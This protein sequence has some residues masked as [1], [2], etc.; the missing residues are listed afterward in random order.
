MAARVPDQPAVRGG[1]RPAGPPL[2]AGVRDE[3]PTGHPDVLGSVVGALGLAGVTG[4]LVE[5]P[6][7]GADALVVTAAV[8]GVA[9]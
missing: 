9:G 3:S 7:R 8:V 1:L 6:V 2:R 5:A 4:A